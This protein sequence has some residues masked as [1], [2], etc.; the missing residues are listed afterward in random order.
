VGGKEKTQN[1]FLEKQGT[2]GRETFGK[3]WIDKHTKKYID[4]STSL[5]KVYIS[6]KNGGSRKPFRKGGGRR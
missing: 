6:Y 5:D 4:K 1:H 2:E 3:I